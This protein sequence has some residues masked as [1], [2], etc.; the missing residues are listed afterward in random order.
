MAVH[1]VGPEVFSVLSLPSFMESA[2]V[3]ICGRISFSSIFWHFR[4]LNGMES[5]FSA[6][7]F[8]YALLKSTFM[9]FKMHHFNIFSSKKKISTE[10]KDNKKKASFY[11]K[12]YYQV[13]E[14][15]LCLVT[16]MDSLHS[17]RFTSFLLQYCRLNKLSLKLLN[18]F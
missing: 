3:S 2:Q 15:C 11:F 16:V 14:K 8:V 17:S 12:L 5:V 10:G 18:F 6:F 13:C 1:A 9:P 7:Y 4:A